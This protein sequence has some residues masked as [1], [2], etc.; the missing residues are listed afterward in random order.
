MVAEDELTRLRSTGSHVAVSGDGGDA[1]GRVVCSG[2]PTSS[3]STGTCQQQQPGVGGVV[4]RLGDDD[5]IYVP[6]VADYAYA[7]H[8]V[9]EWFG[10]YG[11][12]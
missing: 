1:M 4:D 11:L 9:A 5:L 7:D 3:F 8:N 6:D 12:V 2:S 10:L